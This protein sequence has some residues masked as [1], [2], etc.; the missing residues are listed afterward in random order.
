MAISRP[1]GL[2]PGPCIFGVKSGGSGQFFEKSIFV[3]GLQCIFNAVA[4]NGLEA[5]QPW[6]SMRGVTLHEHVSADCD[7]LAVHR[8]RE[9][10][11]DKFPITPS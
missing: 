11:S 3:K 6:L 7:L 8:R 4:V 2:P 9:R 5:I 1:Y 10:V